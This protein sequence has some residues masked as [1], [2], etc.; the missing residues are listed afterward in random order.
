MK[1]FH[2]YSMTWWQIG[3][4]KLYLFVVGL[5]VG[6]YFSEIVTGL[7]PVLFAIFVVLAVYFSYLLAAG[8][9]GE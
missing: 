7:Y 9:M 3:L 4:F 8:E 5:F 6:S 1:L 2:N